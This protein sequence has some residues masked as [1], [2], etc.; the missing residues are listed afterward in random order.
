MAK[1]AQIVEA[2]PERAVVIATLPPGQTANGSLEEMRELL[3][4]ATVDPR[5]TVVQH[6]ASPTRRPTSDPASSTS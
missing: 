5:E 4:T 2:A 6:R 1:P 3:R